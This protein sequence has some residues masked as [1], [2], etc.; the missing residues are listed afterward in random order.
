MQC[1]EKVTQDNGTDSG[2]GRM[3]WERGFCIEG[4]LGL[5]LSRGDILSDASVMKRTKPGAGLE[6]RLLSR[7]NSVSGF[8]ERDEL[9]GY[10]YL[11]KL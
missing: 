8:C 10:I 5:S 6:G 4:D 2:L 7:G 1:N 9:W 3:R 11:N